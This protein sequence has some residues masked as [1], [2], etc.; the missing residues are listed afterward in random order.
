MDTILFLGEKTSPDR[1]SIRLRLCDRH[2][3]FFGDITK[4]C[5]SDL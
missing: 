3:P 2:R 5:R 1:P 4:N